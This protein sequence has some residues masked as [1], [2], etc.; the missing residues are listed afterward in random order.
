MGSD[1]FAQTG[2][3]STAGFHSRLH[4]AYIATHMNAHQTGTDLLGADQGHI[5]G[6]HHGIRRFDRRHQAAGLN[7]S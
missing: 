2:R 5:G 6:L 7:H 3:R 1:D 4:S